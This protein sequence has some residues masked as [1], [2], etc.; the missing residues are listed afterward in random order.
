MLIK[1][2]RLIYWIYIYVSIELWFYILIS[3]QIWIHIGLNC[4]LSI[5]YYAHV[6]YRVL[7]NWFP[8][9]GWTPHDIYCIYCIYERLLRHYS[10]HMIKKL[11][12]K[13]DNINKT[14]RVLSHLAL[15]N[16][17]YSYSYIVIKR[18][19]TKWLLYCTIRGIHIHHILAVTIA[20]V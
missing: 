8:I 3:M 5:E 4:F 20:L 14:K 10:L 2:F 19:N 12:R 9:S 1:C 13:S 18:Y 6:S 7:E 16:R 15:H 11:T 17:I